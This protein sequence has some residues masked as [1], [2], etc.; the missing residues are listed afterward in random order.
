MC[1]RHT[2]QHAQSHTGTRTHIPEKGGWEEEEW[3]KGSGTLVNI[4]GVG[5]GGEGWGRVGKGGEG[6]GRVGKGGWVGPSNHIREGCSLMNTTAH[7]RVP[8]NAVTLWA[9]CCEEQLSF[10]VGVHAEEIF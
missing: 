1:R 2:T 6:W 9:L 5:K 10:V 4:C 8:V 3:T 7:T